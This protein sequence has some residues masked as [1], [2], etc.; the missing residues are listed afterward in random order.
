MSTKD[1]LI[2][3]LSFILE[4]FDNPN[5]LGE[6]LRDWSFVEAT[7]CYSCFDLIEGFEEGHPKHKEK[8]LEIFQSGNKCQEFKEEIENRAQVHYHPKADLLIAWFWDGDGELYFK[9][10]ETE[11]LNTDCKKEYT[12]EFLE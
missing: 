9:L 5:I 3:H 6:L 12:W 4:S 2:P 1:R 8:A 7:G 11:L 10:N